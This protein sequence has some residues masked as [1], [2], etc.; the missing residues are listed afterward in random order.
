MLSEAKSSFHQLSLAPHR[1]IAV[2]RFASGDDHGRI[3]TS[4]KQRRQKG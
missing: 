3:H 1:A 4:Q 2:I